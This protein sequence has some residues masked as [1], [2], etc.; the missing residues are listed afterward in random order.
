MSQHTIEY[1]TGLIA[2]LAAVLID[3]LPDILGVPL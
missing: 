2:L 3:R 1:V